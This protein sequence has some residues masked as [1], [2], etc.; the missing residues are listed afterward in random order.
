M[1]V[2]GEGIGKAED[3]YPLFVS[4]AVTG[5][6]VEAVVTKTN[7]TYG[8]AKIRK[9][10]EPSQHRA[11][12]ACRYFEKCGGCSVMHMDYELQL[13]T[14]KNLVV[15]NLAKIGQYPEGSYTFEGIIGA[16]SPFNYRNKAQFP[17][18]IEKGK[19]VC[20]FYQKSS[21]TIVPCENC[22]IQDESINTAV[23]IV[24]EFIRKHKLRIYN[25]KNHTGIIRHIYVRHGGGEENPLMVVIVANSAAPLPHSH[26]LA[27]MLLEKVNLKSLVQ[28]INTAKSNTVLG[29]ENITLWGEDAIGASLGDIEFVI[30]P[31]SFFQ[32]NYAQMEKLY[33]KAKEYAQLDGS[34]TVFDLYCGVGSISLFMADKARKVVGVEIVDAAIENAKINAKT[35]NI[36]NAEFHCGDCPKVVDKLIKD[37]YSPDVVVV[38]PPR[39]GCDEE[40]LSLINTMHPEKLVYVS[41]NSSTLARDVKILKDYGYALEKCCAVDMFPHSMHVESVAQLTLSTTKFAPRQVKFNKLSEVYSVSEVAPFGAAANLT[42]LCAKRKTSL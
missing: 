27:E 18:G 33:S 10:T 39:K 24:M 11:K 6:T 13:E 17:V 34:Q 40:M 9:I 19:A 14:K 36:Q 22:M 4:G 15:N 35:N 20:G 29:Y 31:N 7:K 5:D 16:E 2:N 28:N 21:H 42:S 30:S 25:E 23:S 41:C 32:V 3:G 38:D 1:T 8:F 26:E 12:P 37:G